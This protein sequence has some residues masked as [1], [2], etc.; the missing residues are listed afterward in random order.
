MVRLLL[1]LMLLVTPA[2]AFGQ[3]MFAPGDSDL[4][5]GQKVRVLIDGT[6]PSAPCPAELIKGRV[7]ELSTSSLVI[8]DG[9]VRRE[10]PVA[11]IAFVEGPRDRIWNGVLAGFAVG[12]T[13]AFVSV[14]ADPCDGFCPFNGTE[15]AAAL[16]LF[17]GGIGAG[18]GAIMDASKSHPRIL[19]A[20]SRPTAR[21]SPVT[22]SRG[23]SFSVRF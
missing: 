1:A 19:F 15:F 2:S 3:D 18:V 10:L 12:F 20:R 22:P 13:I 9:R 5:I 17:S 8:D 23:L 6:C 11:K 7:S 16:G 21:L 14:I 4:R